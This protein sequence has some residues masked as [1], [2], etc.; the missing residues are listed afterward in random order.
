M[1]ENALQEA[2]LELAKL[3]GWRI[4]HFRPARRADGTWRT[5][6]QGHVGFPDLVLLRPPRL[7]CAELK[8][9]K[10]QVSHEQSLWLNGLRTVHNVET[11]EWRP[12]D[13]DRGVVEAVLR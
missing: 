3:L 13:W 8:S 4:A 7:I 9:E 10:G 5:A 12:R 2:I 11:Y 6:M 1:S